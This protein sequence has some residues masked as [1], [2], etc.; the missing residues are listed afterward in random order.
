VCVVSWCEAWAALR[1]T[2]GIDRVVEDEVAELP[3]IRRQTPVNDGI[4]ASSKAPTRLAD[5]LEVEGPPPESI[6]GYAPGEL[7]L[8]HWFPR[9]ALERRE[10]GFFE[11]TPGFRT[12][13][14]RDLICGSRMRVPGSGI[15]RFQIH[16]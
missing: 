5:G 11:H 9:S 14:S 1:E 10:F 16:D 8:T 12:R 3:E 13:Q 6:T 2:E 15:R 4:Q 7:L